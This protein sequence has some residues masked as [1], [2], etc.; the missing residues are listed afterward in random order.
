MAPNDVDDDDDKPFTE[1]LRG[2]AGD[3]NPSG[4]AGPLA[5]IGNDGGAGAGTYSRGTKRRVGKSGYRGVAL[6]NKS[7]RYRARIT[8]TAGDGRQRA[9]GYFETKELAA[10]AW[11]KAAREI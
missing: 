10:L 1:I 8:S 11:D 2:A 9:L 4:G 3:V 6:H 7:G 5:V